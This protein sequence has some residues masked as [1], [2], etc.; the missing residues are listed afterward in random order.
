MPKE[1]MALL[2]HPIIQKLKIEGDKEGGN[3][4]LKE[5]LERHK[6][7]LE[8]KACICML[9]MH[10]YVL[11]EGGDEV[12]IN[13]CIFQQQKADEDLEVA[14]DL[15]RSGEPLFHITE[16]E[17]NN[18]VEYKNYEWKPSVHTSS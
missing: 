3:A 5:S 8:H 10:V 17:W 14:N 1:P 12:F 4:V 7:R 2:P 16:E 6:K 11:L 15:F 18:Y 9:H 13:A